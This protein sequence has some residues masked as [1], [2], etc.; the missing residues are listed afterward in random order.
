MSLDDEP[1]LYLSRDDPR[2]RSHPAELETNCRPCRSEA[3][4]D[5]DREP[6]NQPASEFRDRPRRRPTYLAPVIP[7]NSRRP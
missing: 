1:L 5:H 7:I 4:A 6:E 2:C 3:I